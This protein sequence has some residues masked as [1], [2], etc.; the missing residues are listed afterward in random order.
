MRGEREP[1]LRRTVAPT[2]LRVLW[3]GRRDQALVSTELDAFRDELVKRKRGEL[4]PHEAGRV[5]A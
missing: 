3:A 5:Y 2:E 1:H 4:P